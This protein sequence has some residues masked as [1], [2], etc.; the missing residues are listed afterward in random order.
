MDSPP[1]FSP[2]LSSNMP[3]T[4]R[5]KPLLGTYLA[6]A[7]SLIEE[8]DAE[9]EQLERA[10]DAKRQYREQY[11]EGYKEH[12][13][14]QS[15]IRDIPP[16]VW[17]IIFGFTL[18][19]EPF[20]LWEYRT[21]GYLREVCTIWRDVVAKTPDICRGLVVHLDGHFFQ[22][23]HSDGSGIQHVKDKLKPWLAIMSRNLPYHLVLSTLDDNSFN[24]GDDSVMEAVKWMFTTDPAPTILS[25]YHSSVFTS[26]YVFGPR[27]NTITH[28]RLSFCQDVYWTM[29]EMITFEEVFPCL[30]NLHLDAPVHI[31]DRIGHAN[32]QSLTLTRIYGFAHEFSSFLLNFP[33]LRE[34]KLDSPDPCE[35]SA[36]TNSPVSLIHPTLETLVVDG[37]DMMLLLENIT[38]PSLRFLGLNCWGLEDD[39]ELLAEI[40]PA[41]LQRC[42]LDDHMFSASITGDPLLFIF[43]LL[44][45]NLPRGTRLHLDLDTE[46]GEDVA[47]EE[48]PLSPASTQAR[49]FIE[50]FCTRRP[51]DFDWLRGDRAYRPGGEPTKVYLPEG[52]FEE[53]EVEL[54]EEEVEGWGYTLEFLRMKAY[55]QLVRSSIPHMPFDWEV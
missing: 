53:D 55:K 17:G 18:G 34:L 30:T 22:G 50:V 6:R 48:V 42:S 43:H 7:A 32:V 2:Y 10:L 33:S 3:L 52:I 15:S 45:H 46:M 8:V 1:E 21:Y 44:I 23:P 35:R 49:G 14:L 24:D 5:L 39:H 31:Q 11:K 27:D 28:L 16:E 13:G 37:E 4:P 38:L 12:L 54:V 36:A 47:R 19:D 20:G 9:I 25:I 51:N 26:V 40:I 41:F 29:S